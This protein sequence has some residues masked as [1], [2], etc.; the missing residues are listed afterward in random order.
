MNRRNQSLGEEKLETMTSKKIYNLAVKK[1]ETGKLEYL[2]IS[3]VCED[4]NEKNLVLYGDG[5]SFSVGI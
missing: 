1:L 4:G 3:A 2:S 5:T